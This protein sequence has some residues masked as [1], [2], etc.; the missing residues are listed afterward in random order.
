[1][2]IGARELEDIGGI[3]AACEALHMDFTGAGELSDDDR[4]VYV[5]FLRHRL[6]VWRP[7]TVAAWAGFDDVMRQLVVATLAERATG[8]REQR[9]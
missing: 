3:Y 1:M 7:Q 4:D 6:E 2:S 9:R 8:E 5:A